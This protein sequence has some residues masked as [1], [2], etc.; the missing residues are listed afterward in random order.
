MKQLG[1]LAIVCA[2]RSDTL[3]Q[4]LNG[5][6]SVHVGHGPDKETLSAD[7]RDDEKVMEFIMELNHGRLQ[8]KIS[9]K[10]ENAA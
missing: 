4:V 6:I 1:N 3:L 10:G 5:K 8:E 2:Q 9:E 7:W